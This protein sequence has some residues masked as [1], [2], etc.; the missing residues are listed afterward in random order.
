MKYIF[1]CRF[2]ATL[3]EKSP[4][5]FPK[6]APH[7]KHANRWEASHKCL[8][9]TLFTVIN[10][11]TLP[12]CPGW[13]NDFIMTG[14]HC[15]TPPMLCGSPTGFVEDVL[16]NTPRQV[17]ASRSAHMNGRRRLVSDH[18]LVHGSTGGRDTTSEACCVLQ[19]MPRLEPFRVIIVK[20]VYRGRCE[21]VETP[22]W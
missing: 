13:Q 5:N 3:R 12:V 16:H 7:L 11:R 10:K 19:C 17:G 20:L 22:W 18:K 15:K 1:R 21:L 14:H 4:I 2:S 6:E 8:I 9:E